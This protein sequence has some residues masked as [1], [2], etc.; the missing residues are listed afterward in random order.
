MSFG[1]D[2][3]KTARIFQM[4]S[5]FMMNMFSVQNEVSYLSSSAVKSIGMSVAI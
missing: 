4:A 2:F 3:S 1:S 5:G